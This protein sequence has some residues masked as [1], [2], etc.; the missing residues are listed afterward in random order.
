M[1]FEWYW[2][3]LAGI[4]MVMI[5]CLVFTVWIH[6]SWSHRGIDVSPGVANFSRIWLWMIGWY[7]PNLIQH[8]AATHRKHHA[9]S[10]QVDDPHSPHYYTFKEL[11]LDKVDTQ[12][13]SSRPYYMPKEEVAKWAGDVPQYNDWLEQN[14]FRTY[15]TKGP[16]ILA[17]LYLIVFGWLG[18]LV[19]LVWMYVAR[20][21]ARLHNYMSHTRGYRNWPHA[22]PWDKSVNIIPIG[23]I[24][25]GEELAA[26]HHDDPQSPKLS[27]RWFEF[28]IGWVVIL[29]LAKLNLVT[30]IDARQ[31]KGHWYSWL[32]KKEVDKAVKK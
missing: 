11:V 5:G 20:M 28:D 10:D 17:T 21:S 1:F 32:F 3:N 14:I 29:L 12:S 30:F 26:N 15:P 2:A 31:L 8:F 9:R 27:R 23:I 22:D 13:D 19:G 6:R 25:A 18:L 16:W 4:I 24:W 7:W